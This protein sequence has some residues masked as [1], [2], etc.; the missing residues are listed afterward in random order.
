MYSVERLSYSTGRVRQMHEMEICLQKFSL[1]VA[2][3]RHHRAER[4]KQNSQWR[5]A[6]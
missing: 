1:G 3:G 2:W 5:R 6:L 4:E